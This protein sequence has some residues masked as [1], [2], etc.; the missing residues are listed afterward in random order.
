MFK[1]VTDNIRLRYG[2]SKRDN[3][4]DSLGYARYDKDKGNPR[5]KIIFSIGQNLMKN[6][7]FIIGDRI[8]LLYD[9]EAGLGLMRRIPADK[10]GVTI[11]HA[12][13]KRYCVVRFPATSVFPIIRQITNLDNVSVDE[14]G[15]LFAWPKVSNQSENTGVRVVSLAR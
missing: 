4:E 3:V 12:S 7:R 8:E 5:E 6:A 1:S 11:R 9:D 14:E 15:I 10:P 13:T 2:N